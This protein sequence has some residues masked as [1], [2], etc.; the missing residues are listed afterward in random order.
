MQANTQKLKVTGLAAALV[1]AVGTVAAVSSPQVD[2]AGKPE[3]KVVARPFNNPALAQRAG[4]PASALNVNV[5]S[6]GKLSWMAS[7]DELQRYNAFKTNYLRPAQ[8]KVAA[9]VQDGQKMASAALFGVADTS[10]L[11]VSPVEFEAQTHDTAFF[12]YYYYLQVPAGVGNDEFYAPI[13]L[14]SGAMVTGM[15][16]YGNDTSA[17]DDPDFYVSYNCPGGTYNGSGTAP[18]AHV[19]V[20]F[21]G[22]D[23]AVN[24]AA[25]NLVID[26]SD[27]TYSVQ[28]DTSEGT[29]DVA[30]YVYG[31]AVRFKRQISPDPATTTFTDVSV[32]S[33]FHREIEAMAASGIA[34]GCGGGN[35]CPNAN[36]TRGQMAAFL[37]RALGLHWE[38]N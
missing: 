31:V 7:K 13:S 27:C 32:G 35:F 16:A 15:T 1:L 30:Q 38:S 18:Q 22:G 33:P 34:G 28:A 26:N 6:D 14:P 29:T 11:M 2:A 24:S 12:K 25:S 23:Y 3:S 5:T 21:N 37:S 10:T 8:K 9:S 19:T 20:G 36:V 17:A 4:F